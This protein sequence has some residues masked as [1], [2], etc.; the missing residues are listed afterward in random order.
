[1]FRAEGRGCASGGLASK[2]TL[3]CLDREMVP[4]SQKQ[5]V[6]VGRG[7]GQP[8][9]PEQEGWAGGPCKVGKVVGEP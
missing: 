3:G 8:T 5:Q 1:M 2:H 4:W 6:R 7:E 9:W